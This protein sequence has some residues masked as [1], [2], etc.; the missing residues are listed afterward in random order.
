METKNTIIKNYIFEITERI[1]RFYIHLNEIKNQFYINEDNNVNDKLIFINSYVDCLTKYLDITINIYR[2]LADKDDTQ[3]NYFSYLEKIINNLNHLH[4]NYLGHLPRPSEPVEL[5]RFGRIIE[6]HILNLNKAIA[7]EAENIRVKNPFSIYLSEE[8]G[9]NTYF[10]DPI[11]EFKDKELNPFINKFNADKIKSIELINVE[12]KNN[13]T[14]HISIPRIDA[15]NPCR[16]ST[17]MHEVAH[18]IYKKEYFCNNEIET[19]FLEK[20]DK[21][22]KLFVTNFKKTINLKSWLIECWCDLFGCLVSGPAFWFSQF[23]AFIFQENY[24]KNI[25]NDIYPKAL[26]R[27][28]LIR[29]ILEHRFPSFFSDKL[30]DII[31]STESILKTLDLSDNKGFLKN[32]D[33]RQL[34]Q[35]FRIYFLN[36]FFNSSDEELSLVHQH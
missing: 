18:K 14:F 21:N 1:S 24:D 34:F 28:T 5:K 4:K 29:R 35:Y 36:Y 10:K 6:K 9:E 16:W 17:L 2:D 7:S 27:L 8:V 12:L 23:S 13:N 31:K 26:F 22:Q 32:D 11:F 19:D 30:N 33:I 15:N 20:L 3:C 25:I